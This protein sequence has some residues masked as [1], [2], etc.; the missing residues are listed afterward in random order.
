MQLIKPG[1]AV[2]L[3]EAFNQVTFRGFERGRTLHLIKPGSATEMPAQC[4]LLSAD[5]EN[6]NECMMGIRL[7]H[8]LEQKDKAAL[9]DVA[10]ANR[11]LTLED[12]ARL[13]SGLKP[14]KRHRVHSDRHRQNRHERRSVGALAGGA[15]SLTSI[16]EDQDGES[17]DRDSENG[18]N[19]GVAT[20]T[21]SSDS[22][23][24]VNSGRSGTS[25]SHSTSELSELCVCN[26]SSPASLGGG[27]GTEDAGLALKNLLAGVSRAAKE[28]PPVRLSPGHDPTFR[29]VQREGPPVVKLKRGKD[30]YD[31][32]L[33]DYSCISELR[34]YIQELTRVPPLRRR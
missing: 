21:E 11:V 29:P 32:N 28:R 20:D 23:G 33:D 24:S 27:A 12:L 17:S 4:F 8:S 5:Q 31:L 1:D 22:K 3:K 6:P 9:W 16:P 25:E 26:S 34:A 30:C 18:S 19:C 13:R 7:Q 14:H 2:A 15:V 10:Q